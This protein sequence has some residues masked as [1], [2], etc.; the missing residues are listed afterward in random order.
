[1]PFAGTSAAISTLIAEEGYRLNESGNDSRELLARNTNHSVYTKFEDTTTPAS[2]TCTKKIVPTKVFINEDTSI[3]KSVYVDK[4]IDR[5]YSLDS[6][7]G[8]DYDQYTKGRQFIFVANEPGVLDADLPAEGAAYTSKLPIFIGYNKPGAAIDFNSVRM[9]PEWVG[10]EE[11]LNEIKI[12][13]IYT[14]AV[15]SPTITSDRSL[16]SERCVF[17]ESGR[18]DRSEYEDN[19]EIG[20]AKYFF[21]KSGI[22]QT[23][24]WSLKNILLYIKWF[25]CT[26]SSPIIALDTGDRGLNLI[27]YVADYINFDLARMNETDL[28][29]IEPMDFDIEGLGVLD[30]IK[31]VLKESKKYM[32]YKAYR[33]DGKVTIGYRAKFHTDR[34]AEDNPML[35]RIGVQNAATASTNLINSANINLNRET[36]NIG[37]VIVLGDYLRI[38]TLCSTLAYSGF[39]DNLSSS[40]ESYV[41][42][43]GLSAFTDRLR[44]IL[45]STNLIETW[46]QNYAI[47]NGNMLTLTLADL[48]ADMTSYNGETT[49]LKLFD[50]LKL[51]EFKREFLTGNTT[52]EGEQVRDIGVYIAKPSDPYDFDGT[53]YIQP[54]V[55]DGS[56]SYYFIA[57]A[58]SLQDVFSVKHN[59]DKNKSSLIVCEANGGEQNINSDTGKTPF[60]EYQYTSTVEVS[61]IASSFFGGYSA[62]NP[63]PI[64]IRTNVRTDYRI[65]GIAQI[66]GYEPT[67]HSTEIVEDM[68]FK[69]SISHKDATYD[70][71][72][73][74]NNT[75]GFLDPLDET[76]LEK[77]QYK[78][79]SILD[80]YRVIQNSGF[81][82]FNGYQVYIKVGDWSDKFTGSGRDIN[83]PVVVSSL[84]FDFERRMTTVAF[85]S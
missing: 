21:N 28:P 24:F 81:A 6:I 13:G 19:T 75:N 42:S 82:D 54:L 33:I 71:G 38:N 31:K 44:M 78:A 64:F 45:T 51:L 11:L 40:Y 61:D 30:A 48:S 32:L 84:V 58:E 67:I 72:A 74:T 18:K 7:L 36:K 53:D 15:N 57:P 63:I 16:S 43:G 83:T 56:T 9:S 77:I 70:G 41:S 5:L 46:Q 49:S 37:R 20:G 25:Y 60:G 80:K 23:K 68:D 22:G 50:G 4:T 34:F 14:N 3:C 79:Q 73:F 8:V 39:S 62:S 85:G 29:D 17:N 1:M 76:I 26:A 55:N 10:I 47:E 12:S 59:E 65:K 69:L 35:L 2:Y 66:A 27:N 52:I